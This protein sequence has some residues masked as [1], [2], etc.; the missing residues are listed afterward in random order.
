MSAQ[1]EVFS[2][3]LG[4]I[5]SVLGIA[6][7]T[8]NIWRFPRIA[9]QNGGEDGAGAFLIAW[10]VFLI[11]W[12]IPLIIAEY[13][14]GR[15]GRKGVVQSFADL[16]GEK[17]GW[18]GG[19]VGFV[20]TAIMFYYSVVAGWCLYY[21]TQAIFAPLP[22]TADQALGIWN[23]FQGS[24]WPILTHATVMLLGGYIVLKGI[25]SIEKVNK[26]LIPSLLVVLVI[27]LGKALTL[28]GSGIG[29][30]Y[31]F[32]PDWS[33]L[34]N[35]N[36][37]LEALTQN[38]WDTGAAWGL[39]LT[40][41]TYMRK[42]DDITISAF[43]TGIGNNLVSIT[44]AVII[45]STVF[46]T[47]SSTMSNSEILDVMKT[48]GPASTGLTFI[49]MP[50]L[51]ATMGGGGIF[52]ILFFLGLTF[53]AF[54]S[55][56]SM[57]ELAT[58]VFVDAGATRKKATIFICVFGFAF[59]IPSAMNLT[60]FANQ[61]FVWG[62]GLMVSGAFISY[63]VIKY[64]VTK[65]RTELV[66]TA[67]R[68]TTLGPWWEIVLKYVV[69]VEVVTLLG[70]WMYLSATEYA[71]DSWYNPLSA[72]SVATVL[73]QWAIAIFLVKFFNKKL[74]TNNSKTE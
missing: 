8:G 52:S 49:W 5:L 25:K 56:I 69:P 57:I 35:P 71:P 2:S 29:I 42:K 39:I 68:S 6:V 27:S 73:C 34:T 67:E 63:A 54:S 61:D 45:F 55:L 43:Q 48:S 37:W 28:E 9:A 22:E 38:A 50:R 11:M 59:G 40:Y 19:F 74:V 36:L 62:V 16:I 53:A 41:A 7:G 12:S 66:N 32:T 20:A 24:N 15:N 51:F 18:M 3:K 72:F 23:S 33:D 1:K 14:I 31:L 4:M 21:L 70:W 60:F 47:L 46:G 44:A 10:A 58:K 64:G 30:K 65:F 26:I 17:K 13:G